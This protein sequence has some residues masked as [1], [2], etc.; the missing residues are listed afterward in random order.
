MASKRS[1]PAQGQPHDGLIRSALESLDNARS[2]IA[3]VLPADLLARLDLGRLRPAPA[4][5]VDALLHARE[6]DAVWEVPFAGLDQSLWVHIFAEVQSAPDAD[7]VLRALGVQVRLWERQRRL[8]LALT[9]VIPLVISHGADWRAPRTMLERLKLPAGLEALV[10]PFIPSSTYLLEDLAGF[11]PE[12]LAARADLS[13]SLRVA[14]FI[15]Q[16]SRAASALED[17]LELIVDDL[18]TLSQDPGFRDYL[19]RLLRYTFETANGDMDAVH[20]LL[21]ANLDPSMEIQ[22]G[23]LAEQLIQ[24]G[25][26]KGRT[27]GIREGL[28]KGLQE[29]LVKGIQ[30]GLNGQRE[31]LARQL[32]FKFGVLPG[33]AEERIARA[34][35]DELVDY[36]LRVLSAETLDA[37]FD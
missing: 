22:L 4:R 5:I 31:V 12:T 15:L 8:G 32:A 13:V 1:K 19:T 2:A 16:R 33:S 37:V 9:A 35:R 6:S 28:V 10:A 27:E 17:E 3:A 7:M 18:R 36:S 26:L 24:R 23:T 25:M 29:G 14:Y 30:E 21:R 20:A 34:T 11:A